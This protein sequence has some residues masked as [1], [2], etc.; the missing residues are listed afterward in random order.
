VFREG[1][2]DD[3]ALSFLPREPDSN[4][5]RRTQLFFEV[6]AE[7]DETSWWTLLLPQLGHLISAFSMSEM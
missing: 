2:A 1:A 6:T 7:K 3:R 4:G 5:Q